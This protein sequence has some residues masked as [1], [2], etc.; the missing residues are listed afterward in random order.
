MNKSEIEKANIVSI[1][2]AM[3]PKESNLCK[4]MIESL[5]ASVGHP[6]TGKT[7]MMAVAYVNCE[8]AVALIRLGLVNE[9]GTTPKSK[10]F[11]KETED[12]AL[13]KV[14]AQMDEPPRDKYA[15]IGRFN[16]EVEQEAERIYNGWH[17]KD[18]FVKWTPGGNSEMQDAARRLA[19]KKLE[20]KG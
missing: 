5:L 3:D 10:S 12:E 6:I 15:A 17:T 19:R 9:D 11:T 2:D 18:G 14:I 4:A 20:A 1:I 16:L 8:V 13:D 7:F